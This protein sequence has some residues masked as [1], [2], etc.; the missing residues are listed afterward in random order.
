M[1]RRPGGI[2]HTGALAAWLIGVLGALV[3]QGAFGLGDQ[4]VTMLL[5]HTGVLL[6]SSMAPRFQCCEWAA[7]FGPPR[8]VQ[9]LAL[10][11][12]MSGAVKRSALPAMGQEA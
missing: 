11:L 2:G 12:T 9:T 5:I 8:I 10:T 1:R 3:G 4:A 6:F 7:A